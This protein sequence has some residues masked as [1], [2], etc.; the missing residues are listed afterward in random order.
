MM[1]FSF[2]SEAA[3]SAASSEVSWVLRVESF[4]RSAR[5]L[6]NS[7]V[8]RVASSSRVRRRS[9]RV[10]WRAEAQNQ[11]STAA[12]AAAARAMSA[13]ITSRRFCGGGG[14][15]NAE[16]RRVGRESSGRAERCA[17]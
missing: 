13:M 6:A 16:L 3:R 8:T 5:V 7:A 2:S 11:T 14:R 12:M 17:S 15:G 10:L 1:V 9:T 4:A